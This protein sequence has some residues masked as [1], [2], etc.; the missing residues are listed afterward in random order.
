[1]IIYMNIFYYLWHGK[2]STFEK[3]NTDSFSL[4]NIYTQNRNIVKNR[5]AKQ[6]NYFW[7]NI[8]YYC[9]LL[10]KSIT[11]IQ[12]Y[13]SHKSCMYCHRE[14]VQYL[15]NICYL[16]YLYFFPL[17]RRRKKIFWWI[18]DENTC[19]ILLYLLICIIHVC[20]VVSKWMKKKE[21]AIRMYHFQKRFVIVVV[22]VVM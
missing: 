9:I 12:S 2:C 16:Y 18:F 15:L 3:T 21:Q 5:V 8:F 1:M 11:Y 6:I 7:K 19:H 20:H 17:P 4:V 22:V 14:N 10:E 13:L